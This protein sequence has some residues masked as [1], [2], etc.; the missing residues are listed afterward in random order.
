MMKCNVHK[1][2][3]TNSFPQDGAA[4]QPFPIPGPF[5]LYNLDVDPYEE[6]DVIDRHYWLAEYLKRRFYVSNFA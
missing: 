4:G 6:N 3:C 2:G 1:I 5:E